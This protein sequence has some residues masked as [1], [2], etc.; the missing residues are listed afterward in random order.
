MTPVFIS[1][2]VTDT[3]YAKP[4][5]KSDE[6]LKMFAKQ[7]GSPPINIV[8]FGLG[9]KIDLVKNRQPFDLVYSIEENQWNGSVSLQLKARDIR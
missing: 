8:G 9:N 4:I 5:G 6:H 2:G 7:K 1:K 3:G